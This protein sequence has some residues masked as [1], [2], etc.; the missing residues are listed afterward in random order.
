M[1]VLIQKWLAYK[2]G[3]NESTDQITI[4]ESNGL[5]NVLDCMGIGIEPDGRHSYQ[6]TPLD[7]QIVLF[8]TDAPLPGTLSETYWRVLLILK[9]VAA[10]AHADNEIAEEEITQFLDHIRNAQTLSQV[11]IT[12]LSA[13]LY[14]LLKHPPSSERPQERSRETISY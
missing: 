3:I 10:V 2:R 12:R 9:L 4:D 5:A 8:R 7:S 13:R 14:F 1:D 11:E 6:P